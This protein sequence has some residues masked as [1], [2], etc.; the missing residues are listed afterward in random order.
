M[1]YAGYF[2]SSASS[3]S[4]VDISTLRMDTENIFETSDTSS[5]LT[6]LMDHKTLLLFPLELTS[7]DEPYFIN[8]LLTVAQMV[9]LLELRMEYIALNR[10]VVRCF[11]LVRDITSQNKLALLPI[12]VI[13]HL[14]TQYFTTSI[15]VTPCDDLLLRYGTPR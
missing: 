10:G 3:S 6:R 15:V 4:G 8:N 7:L 12:D 11:C 13:S 1:V 9:T 5:I 14:K 2:L